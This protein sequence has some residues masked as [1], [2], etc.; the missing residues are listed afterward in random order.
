MVLSGR[1]D[2]LVGDEGAGLAKVVLHLVVWFVRW[3]E[4]CWRQEMYL[5][6]VKVCFYIAQYPVRWSAQRSLHFI[7]GRRVHS[8]TNSTS[9]GSILATQQLRVNYSLIF[10]PLSTTRYSITHLSGLRHSEKNENA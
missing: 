10:P 7:L 1:Y 2:G 3:I 9:P 6:K 5:K 8:D 4:K